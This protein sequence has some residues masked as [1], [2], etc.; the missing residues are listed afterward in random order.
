MTTILDRIANSQGAFARGVD[1]FAARV[2]PRVPAAAACGYYRCTCQRCAFGHYQCE[3][4]QG[5]WTG[6]C[7]CSSFCTC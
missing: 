7:T 4:C 6:R 3:Y 1:R 5:Y 2:L